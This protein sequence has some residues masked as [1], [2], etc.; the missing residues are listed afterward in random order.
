MLVSSRSKIK[1]H[2]VDAIDYRGIENALYQKNP[3]VTRFDQFYSTLVSKER[4]GREASRSTELGTIQVG[5]DGEEE[6]IAGYGSLM[7]RPFRIKR[8]QFELTSR[9]IGP[10]LRTPR[11]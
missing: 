4:W 3:R 5:F 6:S 10:T 1:K 8:K 9:G 2:L 7:R 11:V